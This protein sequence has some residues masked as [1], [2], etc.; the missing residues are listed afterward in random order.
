[1]KVRD[2]HHAVLPE[3]N[4]DELCRQ[5]AVVSLRRLLNNKVR[6]RNVKLFESEAAPAFAECYGRQPHSTEEIREAFMLSPSYRMWSAVNRAAQEMIWVSVGEPIY[7]DLQRMEQ[8]AKEL[9]E[10]DDKLGSLSLD[11]LYNPS[12]EV[13]D[14]DIHLQ[15]GG[16]ALNKSDIDI[17]S[18]A[19]YEC[20]G[21]V[22]SFGQGIGRN[23]SKAAVITRLL[24]QEFNGF[25]PKK[26]LDIGCSA[27]AASAAYADKWRDTEVHAV[28]LGAG[29]LRYAHARAESLG[30]AVHFHQMDASAM[31]F[32]DG[33]FDFVVSHN[34]MHEIGEEKRRAMFRESFRLVRPG[35]IVIHQDVPIRN[36]PTPIH[37]VERD[38]DTHYNG[39]AHWSTY[40]QADLYSDMISAGFSEGS[41]IE[42]DLTTLQGLAN[43]RWYVI[44]G[45]KPF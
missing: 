17:V 5:N 43:S 1:M 4:V 3:T 12:P 24:E 15:P 18:G 38:W 45:R 7:R 23:D 41:V 32:E 40:A 42:H 22:F 34:L 27:G 26:I 36:Q 13:A 25:I 10:R 39:E 21:N 35:G 44:S 2:I 11:P 9:V 16:Y 30:V 29:M 33:S 28:D 20:G 14:I 19:L 8:V 37:E 6:P 31:K